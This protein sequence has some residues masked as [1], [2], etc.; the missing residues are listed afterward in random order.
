MMRS[1]S[2]EIYQEQDSDDGVQELLD[3]VS[4]KMMSTMLTVFF[5]KKIL[6]SDVY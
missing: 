1:R 4:G 5:F 6:M 3:F 2:G